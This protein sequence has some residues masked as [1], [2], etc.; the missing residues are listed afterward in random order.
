[1]ASVLS[2]VAGGW[3]VLASAGRS[4]ANRPPDTQERLMVENS[5]TSGVVTRLGHTGLGTTRR[6]RVVRP[7]GTRRIESLSTGT[8][9]VPLIIGDRTLGVLRLGPIG[10]T[11]F[12][13]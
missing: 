8:A 1:G 3:R 2:P 4:D 9:F 11:P 13:E 5:A 12:G 10:A 7:A 6:I